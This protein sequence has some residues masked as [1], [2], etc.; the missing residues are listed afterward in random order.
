[1]I[2][3]LWRSHDF[4]GLVLVSIAVA[5]YFS[6]SLGRLA[7]FAICW[8]LF[9]GLL[10]F[11]NPVEFWPGIQAL[12]DGKSG[13][14]FAT[15]LLLLLLVQEVK[16][17]ALPLQILEFVIAINCMVA[18]FTKGGLFHSNSMDA[19]MGAVILPA[20]LFRPASDNWVRISLGLAIGVVISI[21]V[22]GGTT[23]F[24]AI[25]AGLAAMT[26]LHWRKN[27]LAALGALSFFVLICWFRTGKEFLNDW[28]RFQEWQL[29]FDWWA[30]KANPLI[31]TGLGSFE[32]LGPMIQNKQS[33]LYL[34]M[35]NEYLQIL[36]ELGAIGFLLSA[37]V[38]VKAL[39]KSFREPWLFACLTS[40]SVVMLTQFPLRFFLSQLLFMVLLKF[41]WS[42]I[43]D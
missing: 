13:L 32:I 37:A 40:A 28:G 11:A 27:F 42:Q 30:Q 23:A 20:L 17:Y 3:D 35:H 41:A 31:G 36:F 16:P 21:L 8:V 14:A 29:F 9:S 10:M 38:W 7:G 1:M 22:I 19:S 24:F 43:D 12:I 2:F 15:F 33:G 25:G 4:I 5:F 18:A 6:K 39:I 26:F 34:F